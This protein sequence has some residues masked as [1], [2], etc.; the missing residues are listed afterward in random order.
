MDIILLY[1]PFEGFILDYYNGMYI[2]AIAAFPCE[3]RLIGIAERIS[4]FQAACKRLSDVARIIKQHRMTAQ[5]HCV[6]RTS[7]SICGKQVSLSTPEDHS[8][9]EQETSINSSS[10]WL[11]HTISA[12]DAGNC[13]SSWTSTSIVFQLEK[14]WIKLN[15]G[16][17]KSV[18][19]LDAVQ[20][21][22]ERAKRWGEVACSAEES[23]MA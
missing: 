17:R 16:E 20:M 21:I 18:Q 12:L 11:V 8:D 22:G 15:E 7:S 3:Q 2:A 9:I 6:F 13:L 5:L 4:S 1:C 10:S 14:A 23:E 19:C